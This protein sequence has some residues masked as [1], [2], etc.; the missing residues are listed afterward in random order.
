MQRVLNS[1]ARASIRRRIR[2]STS[3]DAARRRQDAADRD[4]RRPGC[5]AASTPTSSRR[6]QFIVDEARRAAVSRSGWSAARAAT[7]SRA[8]AST[9]ATSRSASSRS[10]VRDAQAIAHAAIEAFTSGQVDAS[11]R[12]QRVQVGDDAARRRRSAAADSA[13]GSTPTPLRRAGRGGGAADRL[14]VRAVAAGDLQPAA[15]AHVEV[16]VYRALL[17]SNAAF[18]AAQMTAMDAATRTR[19]HDRPA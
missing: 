18:F 3:R 9:C 8:A 19:R 16:Q 2:C 14:P 11:A 5:A 4:H 15:A 12:L 17:E 10:C 6:R 13:R 1:L 7:S